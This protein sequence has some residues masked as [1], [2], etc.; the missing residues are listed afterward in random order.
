MKTKIFYFL[1]FSIICLSFSFSLAFANEN[2]IL[3]QEKIVESGKEYSFFSGNFKISF[4]E[5]SLKQASRLEVKKITSPF[6]WP[7][8]YSPLGAVYE[9]NLENNGEYYNNQLPINI[10]ISYEDNPY[11]KQIFFLDGSSNRFR[12]LPSHKNIDEQYIE[13]NVHFSF[14][15]LAILYNPDVDLKGEASW[16]SFRGGDFAASP[17]FPRGSKIRVH[18]LENG[19]Y[20]DVEIN[21]YGPD[22]SIYPNRIID[23]DRVAFEKIAPSG[24][25]LIDVKLEALHIARAE[26]DF[27]FSADANFPD[28]NANFAIVKSENNGQI[29]FAKEA[30]KV[31]PIA[32]LTKLV[33]ARVFLDLGIDLEIEVVYL[34]EDEKHNHQFVL[35]W[36]SSRLRLNEGEVVR[37]KDLLYSS[38]VGSTN[39]TVE[40]LVRI[41]GL[42]RQE[43]IAR[44][45]IFAEVWGARQTKFVEPTG[46]S[47][48][49]ISSPLDY[50]I[51]MKEILKN[52]LLAEMST[53]HIYNFR[54]INTNR[55]LRVSNTNQLMRYGLLPIN[56][57]KTGFINA[58]GFCLF[59]RVE[60]G[61]D[62][63]IVV[64]F[65]SETRDL[66]Y[67]DHERL[68]NY[69]LRQL[70]D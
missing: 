56:A 40:T 8:N 57:A 10:K 30:D 50:A 14:V 68:V 65:G 64:S 16:Y 7:W 49:N 1:I 52:P 9:F 2:K 45:N 42:D 69:A 46:L 35:P 34:D 63:L 43:F 32:S 59:S 51:I 29:I 37:V 15:R 6:D 22:R 33:A 55:S 5:N 20:V 26:N 28:I 48:D 67:N 62:N 41:S 19:K 11:Y 54:T 36:Q 70:Q 12:N 58:S 53:T 27:V 39:N 13:T 47:R 61:D 24:S 38:L 23:L 17:D 4:P 44:M 18:N 25:G 31:A 21:D 3:S 60:N 66:S